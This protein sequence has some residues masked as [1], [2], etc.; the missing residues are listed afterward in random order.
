MTSEVKLLLFAAA[1]QNSTTD[2]QAEDRASRRKVVY[3]YL[4]VKYIYISQIL[5]FIGPNKL[6]F[7]IA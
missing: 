6:I 2:L 7:L 1:I 5:N 3:L 4:C